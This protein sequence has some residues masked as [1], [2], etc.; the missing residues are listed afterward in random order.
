MSVGRFITVGLAQL[1]SDPLCHPEL[2]AML[3]FRFDEKPLDALLG[4]IE[5]FRLVSDME[6]VFYTLSHPAHGAFLNAARLM[7]A[8]ALTLDI[9]DRRPFA[10]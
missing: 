8:Y 1:I 4:L 3:G 10:R 6:H 7:E 9:A 2:P 5:I